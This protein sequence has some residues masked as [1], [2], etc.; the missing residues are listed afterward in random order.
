M[1][2]YSFYKDFGLFPEFVNLVELRNIFFA[3]SDILYLH[4]KEKDVNINKEETSS[5]L[6]CNRTVPKDVEKKVKD[7]LSQNEY[8][9]F[10]LFLDSL[11]ISS[12]FCRFFD[13]FVVIDRVHN[14]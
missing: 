8:I 9:N 2:K 3:L 5:Q 1:I 7:I 6:E 11:A 12:T 14:I 10:D 4:Y 13:E